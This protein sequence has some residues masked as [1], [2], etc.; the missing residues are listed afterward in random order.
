MFMKKSCYISPTMTIVQSTGYSILAGSAQ[1]LPEVLPGCTEDTATP[2]KRLLPIIVQYDDLEPDIKVNLRKGNLALNYRTIKFFDFIEYLIVITTM[3]GEDGTC[4][5]DYTMFGSNRFMIFYNI[6]DL[7]ELFLVQIREKVDG[8]YKY[9]FSKEVI[10]KMPT[11]CKLF[12]NAEKSDKQP[13]SDGLPMISFLDAEKKYPLL[14]AWFK[15]DTLQKQGDMDK[16]HI[17]L[18]KI[19]N[20]IV[21]ESN[22]AGIL[23]Q[24]K[25]TMVKNILKLLCLAHH[26]E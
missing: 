12:A 2:I 25:K 17:A 15:E 4:S 9:H 23:N 18:F 21:S 13:H 16:L 26:I 5:C 8:V 11:L 14:C 6:Y 3:R 10:Q 1:A 22:N 24:S 19:L 7:I 20:Q